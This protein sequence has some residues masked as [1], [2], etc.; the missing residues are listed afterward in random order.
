[1][2]DVSISLFADTHVGM[3]RAANEDSFLIADL[4]TGENEGGS[5]LVAHALG[6]NGY[7][8]AVSDG[9]GGAAAGEVAS[10]LAVHTLFEELNKPNKTASL[11][12]YLQYASETANEQ[13]W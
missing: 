7:L 11:S 3:R 1:M 13:I 10:D 6:E 9:M 4:T 5:Q 12:A 8:M 2:S